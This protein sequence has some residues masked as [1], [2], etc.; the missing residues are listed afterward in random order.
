MNPRKVESTFRPAAD[1]TAAEAARGMVASASSH[2]TRA[3]VEILEAGGNAFDAACAVAFALSV[4]EPHMS[5]LGGQT[6]GL[7]HRGDRCVALDGSSR[8]PAR[9]LRE[10]IDSKTQRDGYRAA[11][12]PSTPAALAWINRHYGRL[13]WPEVIA[14][15]VRIAREGY[16][17]TPLE[18]E[19][20]EREL[21]PFL[22]SSSRSGARYFL[23]GG[24]RPYA[25]GEVLQQ[26]D[27]ADTLE[28]L[29]KEG[30][31]SFYSG[32]IA[33]RIDA[34]M[35]ENDGFLRADDLALTPWPIE[36]AP[37]RR[38]YRS[39]T[40]LTMPPPGSGR[41]LLLALMML[42]HLDSSFLG[43]RS[44]ESRHFVAETLRKALRQ[45]H[46]RPYDPDSYPQVENKRMLSRTF[47]RELAASITEQIDPGLPVDPNA[48]VLD[49]WDETTHLS[50]MDSEGNAAS[51]TQSI[52][53]AYGAK[54]AANR[55]GF[56]YNNYLMAC[57]TKDP[58]HPYYLRPGGVPWSSA[59]PAIVVRRGRPWIAMGSPGSERISSALAQFL[60]HVVDDS[61]S[62]QEAVDRPRVHCSLGG[63]VSLEAGRF[64]GEVVEHL[65]ERGYRIES[66]PEYSSALGAIQ[67]VLRCQTRRGFQGVAD[68]RRG[69]AAA[70]P[71]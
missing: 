66:M 37:L 32:D 60:M 1:G 53:L 28:Q 34:D 69:G 55:L 6:L 4:C 51:I 3:G 68:R 19:L 29:A 12:V 50:A 49:G 70:G 40:V 46:E 31:E 2:A 61:A 65:A 71:D 27:L 39:T 11:T 67:A 45:R 15:A 47:A 42:N 26:P 8:V 18:S 56:L 5:G 14:P 13:S 20:Q 52:E 21:G 16:P 63:V 24:E 38:R 48:P 36:R 54:V 10:R 44:P 7:L 64:P 59:A 30:V 41:T 62:I 22:E 58:S 33:Q 43:G 9:A 25:A 35:R 17:I 23:R 57:D